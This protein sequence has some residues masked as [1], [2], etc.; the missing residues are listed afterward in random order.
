[1]LK[2]TDVLKLMNSCR[3]FCTS[4]MCCGQVTSSPYD[5]GDVSGNIGFIQQMDLTAHS[6]ESFDALSVESRGVCH[7][8]S[9]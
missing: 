4:T 2:R 6:S 5:G 7:V 8:A 1:M 9:A 3:S